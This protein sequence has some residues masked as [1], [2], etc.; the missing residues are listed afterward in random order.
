V[1]DGK[2]AAPMPVARRYTRQNGRGLDTTG[3]CEQV[4]ATVIMSALWGLEIHW[5]FALKFA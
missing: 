2:A 1:E 5:A 4:H 3:P